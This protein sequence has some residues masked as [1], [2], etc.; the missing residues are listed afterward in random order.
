MK[1]ASKGSL[2]ILSAMGKTKPPLKNHRLLS[3]ASIHYFSLPI[4]YSSRCS[5]EFWFYFLCFLGGGSKRRTKYLTTTT[6]T[7]TANP[8]EGHVI[9]TSCLLRHHALTFTYRNSIVTVQIDSYN[10]AN[11]KN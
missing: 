10:L 11:L 3:S 9:C 4:Y 2:R 1:I 5:A 6:T 8:N 7:T